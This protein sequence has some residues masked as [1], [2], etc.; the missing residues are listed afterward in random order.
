MIPN[1]SFPS[2]QE[3]RFFVDGVLSDT[4]KLKMYCGVVQNHVSGVTTLWLTDDGT[5]GGV[6][7]FEDLVNAAVFITTQLNTNSDVPRS[8]YKTSS[9][10]SIT[11]NTVNGAEFHANTT[12]K[13]HVL[14]IGK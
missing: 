4:N 5:E 9:D 14:I 8:S 1:N 7:I 11:I 10:K 2:I 13:I 6:P 3:V 12:T